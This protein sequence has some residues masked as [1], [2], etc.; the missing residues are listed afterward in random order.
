MTI[1]LGS[2]DGAI[3]ERYL[4]PIITCPKGRL[5]RPFSPTGL[6]G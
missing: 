3:C 2:V 5:C 4:L 6:L 1:L